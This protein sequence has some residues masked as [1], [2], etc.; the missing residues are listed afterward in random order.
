MTD[1]TPNNLL[2][3]KRPHN[4]REVLRERF[5]SEDEIEVVVVLELHKDG[6]QRITSSI[7]TMQEKAFLKA[8]FDSWIIGWFR[9]DDL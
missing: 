1:E 3:F 7:G 2:V 5:L 6:T 4:A 8:F 9:G